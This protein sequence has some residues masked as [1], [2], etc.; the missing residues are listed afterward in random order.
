MNGPA[1]K[2]AIAELKKF[3]DSLKDAPC[4]DCDE[5]FPACAMDFDHRDPEKKAANISTLVLQNTPKELI[6]A[7]I[8][9]CDLVCSNCHRIRTRN[10]RHAYRRWLK[11]AEPLFANRTLFLTRVEVQKRYSVTRSTLARWEAAGRIP[12]RK[13]PSGRLKGR[14]FWL[15]SELD[16]FDARL[17]RT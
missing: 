7:E 12:A 17:G 9:K 13:N 15:L 1:Q 2:A 16:E 8:R 11:S 6:E 4:T 3:V 10:Q 5:R 14:R